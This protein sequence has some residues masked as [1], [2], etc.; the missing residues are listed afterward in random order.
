MKSWMYHIK[1]IGL[2]TKRKTEF[3][4]YQVLWSIPTP[5]YPEPYVTVTVFFFITASRLYPPYFP[6]H[7]SSCIS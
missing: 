2:E 1:F 3:Y 7:V 4:T 6:V 5:A